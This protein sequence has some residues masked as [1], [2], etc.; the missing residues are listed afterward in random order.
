MSTDLVSVII[1]TYNKCEYLSK[2]LESVFTQTY[3]NYEVIVVDDGSTDNTKN[4][5]QNYNSPIHYVYQSN[6]G[7]AAA[8]NTGLRYA[9]GNLIAF[10]DSD[11]IWRPQKLQKSV[12]QINS[13]KT[14]HMVFTNVRFLDHTKNELK[15]TKY[16][17]YH[18]A[19]LRQIL[20]MRC[21]IT[22]SSVLLKR[23]VFDALGHF[24]ES[25]RYAEDWLFFYKVAREYSVGII[26]EP[27]TIYNVLQN[28][29]MRVEDQTR[30]VHD[31][32]AVIDKIF[33]YPENEVSSLTKNQSCARY[34]REI[35]GFALHKGSREEAK[36]YISMAF[37]HDPRSYN[38]FFLYL[39][40]LLKPYKVY[41]IV[42]KAKNRIEFVFLDKTK[43]QQ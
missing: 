10:L 41:N 6:N 7:P 25:L 20:L 28:S 3:K 16:T 22:M 11:D 21:I 43:K 4:V 35:A 39:K 19:N 2:V 40:Y 9:T 17:E 12:Q 23:T 37:Q 36:K 1:P 18:A 31:V 27:L 38:T 32:C 34:L 26:T 8:R 15:V 42:R 29:M 24:D 33:S 13:H 14:H 5:I 30:L